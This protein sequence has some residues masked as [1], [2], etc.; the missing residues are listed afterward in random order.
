MA[1]AKK[2]PSGNW[3]IKVYDYTD[4]TGKRHYASFTATSKKEAE[5]QAAEFALKKKNRSRPENMTVGEA[6]DRYISLRENVL[7]PT[8]ISNYRKARKNTLSNVMKWKLKSITN[9]KL[10][11]EFNQ[12]A[13]T[14]NN[15]GTLPTRKYMD[16]TR[17]LLSAT[18]NEFLPDFRLRVRLP[19]KQHKIKELLPV[20]VVYGIVKDTDIELP[21]LLAMWLSFSASEIRGLTKS[22]SINGD[23]ITI[24]E[25]VVDVDGKSVRKDTG[26]AYYRIRRH[27]IPERIKTLI[28]NVEGDVLVPLSGQAIYKRFTRLQA[29]AGI[30]E[31]DR[32]TF[33]DLRRLNASVM[34]LLRIPDKYAQERG[35]WATDRVM[36]DVYQKTF[37]E[38]RQKV[39]AIIDEYF[40]KETTNAT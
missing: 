26:K 12:W 32:M 18:L 40:E 11:N 24:R 30:P 20:D 14:P 21:V 1:T 9:E 39:D 36:K 25:V 19:A 33:H 10:Q 13:I 17:G 3:N 31:G 38:E 28:S 5:Y 29:K 6:I 35:G 22:K 27:K 23:Y 4:S 34:A 16:N 8:T 37:S 2:L 7:S 15:R